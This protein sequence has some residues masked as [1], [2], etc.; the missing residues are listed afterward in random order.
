MGLDGEVVLRYGR[1]EVGGDE[2]SSLFSLLVIFAFYG[3]IWRYG[4]K[5]AY[6]FKFMYS[7]RMMACHTFMSRITFSHR[8]KNE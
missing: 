6:E 5:T 4:M 2:T 8:K 7:R 3:R 1:I